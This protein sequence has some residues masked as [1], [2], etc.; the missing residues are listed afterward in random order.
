MYHFFCF[1]SAVAL[2]VP[3]NTGTAATLDIRFSP[4]SGTQEDA[5]YVGNSTISQGKS[6]I[7]G[8][9]ATLTGR[10]FGVEQAGKDRWGI[11]A[12]PLDWASGKSGWA[13]ES[14]FAPDKIGSTI[15]TKGGNSVPAS[16]LSIVLSGVTTG[17]VFKDVAIT[18]SD[19]SFLS[20]S[21]AWAGTSADGFASA[22]TLKFTQLKGTRDLT[23]NLPSFTYDSGEPLE[24]RVFGVIGS[25]RG[26]FNSVSLTGGTLALVPEPDIRMLLTAVGLAALVSFRHRRHSPPRYHR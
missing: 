18:F 24:V 2:L 5:L 1:L 17:T 16:Y 9:V 21:K 4:D 26:S 14:G 25:D 19:V 13:V 11:T 23:V 20:T 15:S 12:G 8:I 22:T 6:S 3:M 7:P 10:G